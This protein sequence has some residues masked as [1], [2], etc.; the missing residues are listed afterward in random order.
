M[1]L[2]EIGE[3]GFIRRV[4]R[5]CLIRDWNVVRAIGDDAAAVIGDPE[6][7]TLVTTD[8]LVERIHFLRETI[9]GSELGHKSLAV[10]LSDIAAMGGTA[11]DAFI[12]LGIPENCSIDYMDAFYDGMKALAAEFDINILGG[13]TT[14][15]KQDLIINIA[16]TGS[17]DESQMLLRRGAVPGDLIVST[18]TLGDSRAGLH[19]ILNQIPADESALRFLWQAHVLPKPYLH[20]GRYLAKSGAVTAAIDTSDGLS[21]DIQHIAEES[22]VGARLFADRFPISDPLSTFCRDIESDPVEWAL[23]GGED[24]T[25]LCTISPDRFE[26]VRRG[27]EK[28]FASPLYRI[29]EIIEKR[30][31]ELV[32][33]SG[34]VKEFE[35]LGWDHF[36]PSVA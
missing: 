12:S 5:G 10:N 4:S 1:G 7:L 24:Y 14:R 29:G 8:L 30:K 15:S 3:F 16:V 6:Q 21:S 25:L 13:D 35:A 19:L 20:E 11:R 17:V 23:S 26:S 9:T 33:V 36:R 32:L 28:R 27:Y 18:G 22:G 31:M 2:K 34:E